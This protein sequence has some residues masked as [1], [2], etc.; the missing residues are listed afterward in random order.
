MS[1]IMSNLITELEK[2][3]E[4]FEEEKSFDDV[5]NFLNFQLINKICNRSCSVSSLESG[6]SDQFLFFPFKLKDENLVFLY[7]ENYKPM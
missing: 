6:I 4:Q 2:Y 5:K 3:S 7:D 1:R